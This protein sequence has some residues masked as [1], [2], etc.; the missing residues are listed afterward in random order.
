MRHQLTL[1]Q[2]VAFR[3]RMILTDTVQEV[4]GYVILASASF[5]MG[6]EVLDNLSR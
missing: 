6:W 2:R 3:A 1:K 4:L 5:W